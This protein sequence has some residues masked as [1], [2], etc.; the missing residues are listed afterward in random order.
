MAKDTF[1]FSHD[2]NVRSDSKIKLLIR[3]HGML[4]YGIWWSIVEDLYNNANALPM[5]CDGIAFELRVDCEVV[6]SIINDFNLF[7]IENNAFRSL[8]I[9]S[10]LDERN[11]KS[12]KAKISANKRWGDANALRSQSDGNAKKERKGNKG[13]EIKVFTAPSADEV[14]SF[15]VSEGYK[16][17]VAQRAWKYYAD[18]EWKDSYN[19]PVKNWKQKMRGNWFKD[20]HK[21]IVNA[22]KSVVI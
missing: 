1:Y 2:Y 12:L 14:I 8:S 13:K 10:R 21:N 22:K 20:E 19:K 7:K 5:D 6:K 3:K 18:A 9:E 11:S 4:G 17:D 16:A 15:F